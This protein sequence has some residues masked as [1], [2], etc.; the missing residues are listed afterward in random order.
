MKM[1]LRKINPFKLLDD[2]NTELWNCCAEF[3]QRLE[4]VILKTKN[5]ML[6][7]NIDKMRM[8]ID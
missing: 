2:H 6:A 1:E 3:E 7:K 4:E 5:V 8:S